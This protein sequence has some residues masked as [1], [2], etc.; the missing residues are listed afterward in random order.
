MTH[1]L[2]VR[3]GGKSASFDG[4]VLEVAGL[5]GSASSKR[6]AIEVLE[7][8]AVAAA[9]DELMFVVKSRKG[10]FG[11]MISQARRGDWE[12]LALRVNASRAAL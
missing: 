3:D 8:A 6:V 9:G 5:S 10:G 7:S 12:Q 11:L 1:V 2:Q 4:F